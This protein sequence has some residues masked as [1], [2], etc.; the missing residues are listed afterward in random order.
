MLIEESTGFI[1]YDALPPHLYRKDAC[2]VLLIPKLLNKPYS[3]TCKIVEW[4]KFGENLIFEKT[5]KSNP[6]KEDE[7]EVW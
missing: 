2:K 1:Y 5:F 7:Y 4:K 6:E 3:Y